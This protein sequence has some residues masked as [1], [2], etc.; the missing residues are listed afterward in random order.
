MVRSRN[1]SQNSYKTSAKFD[2]VSAESRDRMRFEAAREIWVDGGEKK[3][4]SVGE[5][6]PRSAAGPLR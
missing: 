5:K 6:L 4:T 3:D 2:R 1:L